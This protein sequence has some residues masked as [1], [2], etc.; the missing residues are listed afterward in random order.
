[1]T[2]RIIEVGGGSKGIVFEFYFT[3][4]YGAY[5]LQGIGAE[6]GGVLA[7]GAISYIYF[8]ARPEFDGRHNFARTLREHNANARAYSD[9]LDKLKIK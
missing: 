3:G 6:G 1:M 5:G 8:C 4:G 2:G 7:F 9:A